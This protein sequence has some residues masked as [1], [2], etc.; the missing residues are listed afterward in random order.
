MNWISHPVWSFVGVAT[1]LI[2]IALAIY[3]YKR[4]VKKKRI[5]YNF[6]HFHLVSR[7]VTSLPDFTFSYKGANLSQLTAT[8]FI[9][10]NSGTD[11]VEHKDVAESDSIRIVLNDKAQI[12]KANVLA[13]SD[14]TNQCVV[15]LTSQMPHVAQVNFDYIGV[16][17]G[18]V[19]SLMV[20]GDFTGEIA[21]LGTVKGNGNPRYNPEK[22]FLSSLTAFLIGL[23]SG[24]IS[25]ISILFLL[26]R[27]WAP[28]SLFLF[29]VVLIAFAISNRFRIAFSSLLSRLA[30]T[31]IGIH[32]RIVESFEGNFL[33][34]EFA[35]QENPADAV[36]LRR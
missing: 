17:Q 15:T 36:Q 19:V 1:G 12:L 9:F 21:L 7:T 3:F 32:K 20:A 29:I 26:S 35:Y 18:A 33:P 27:K 4:S 30:P 2:G 16:G 24:A 22:E 5:S 6:R 8:K 31:R 14:P 28:L 11:I 10:W 13:Q 23:L 34:N 25:F